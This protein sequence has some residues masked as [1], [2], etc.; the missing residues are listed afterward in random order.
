[1][2][3]ETYRMDGMHDILKKYSCFVIK[4]LISLFTFFFPSTILFLS[5]TQ[6]PGVK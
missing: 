2:D 6:K 3:F 4:T 1:M 5:K